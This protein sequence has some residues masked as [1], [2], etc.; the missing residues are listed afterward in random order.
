MTAGGGPAPPGGTQRDP[1]S[2]DPSPEG[3]G[4]EQIVSLGEIWRAEAIVDALGARRGLPPDAMG[5]PAVELLAALSEDVDTA[6]RG[7][8]HSGLGGAA[9]SGLADRGAADRGAADRGA[10]DRGAAHSGPT[11]RG[12]AARD[13]PVLARAMSPALAAADARWSRAEPR[14]EIFAGAGQPEARRHGRPLG[15]ARPVPVRALAIGLVAAAAAVLMAVVAR[16]SSPAGRSGVALA[17]LSAELQS[18]A[19][20]AGKVRSAGPRHSLV[21]VS[22]DRPGFGAPRPAVVARPPRA[23]SSGPAADGGVRAA[24]PGGSTR[25]NI[26]ADD[27]S[28]A[29]GVGAAKRDPMARP[30]PGAGRAA[31]GQPSNGHAGLAAPDRHPASAPRLSWPARHGV[32]GAVGTARTGA[33][34]RHPASPRA[35]A[36]PGTGRGARLAHPPSAQPWQFWLRG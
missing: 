29:R 34:A 10:A 35:A 16:P 14:A 33:H 30:G 20:H 23:A 26:S 24:A 4:S 21:G 17:P 28:P 32:T 13:T 3:E 27:N 7:T 18:A 1:D 12:I 36:G 22:L 15:R 25:G 6:D 31:A 8:A 5:D 9:L 2:P 11:D 19:Q